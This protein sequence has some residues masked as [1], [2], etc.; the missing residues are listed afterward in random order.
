[1]LRR[2][3][4]LVLSILLAVSVSA[5]GKADDSGEGKSETAATDVQ[6]WEKDLFV[7]CFLPE[8]DIADEFLKIM[9]GLVET[10]DSASLRD[11]F[12]ENTVASCENMDD[13][14]V[15]LVDFWQ[16]DMVSCERY[17]P[18]SH[19]EKEGEAYYKEICASYDVVTS[20]GSYRLAF[21]L[22][23]VDTEVPEN[24]GLHSVYIIKAED[25]DMQFA[26]WGGGIWN[27]GI[28]IEGA[29]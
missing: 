9:V 5:C 29:E 2:V 20:S 28:V 15:E 10:E 16:G 11:L 22:C 6:K 13:S 17:G 19:T 7:R 27:D 23:I 26:Y 4:V 25:S 21:K 24:L 12:S 18:M 1:M 8:A 14:I 3:F